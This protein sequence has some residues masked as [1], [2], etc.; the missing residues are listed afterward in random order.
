[1]C[2]GQRHRVVLC[3][4]ARDEPTVGDFSSVGSSGFDDPSGVSTRSKGCRKISPEIF[5]D[6]GLFR[7]WLWF[8]RGFAMTVIQLE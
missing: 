7:R 5:S 8:L 1:M 4:E 6:N 2:E 3:M